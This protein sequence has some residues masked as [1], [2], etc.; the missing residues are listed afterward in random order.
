MLTQLGILNKKC[1][2]L[3]ALSGI[4]RGP[5]FLFKNPQLCPGW[6]QMIAI[7]AEI[8]PMKATEH[9]LR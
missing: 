3:D 5:H 7:K 9:G 4:V 1:G 8:M 2:P 6:K